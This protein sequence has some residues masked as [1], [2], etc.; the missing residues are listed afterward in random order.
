MATG[1]IVA[2]VTRIGARGLAAELRGRTRSTR[3]GGGTKNTKCTKSRG[4]RS[5][6]K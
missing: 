1:A 3:S 5:T 4:S 6:K 2:V